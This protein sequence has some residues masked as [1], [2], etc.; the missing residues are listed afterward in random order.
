MTEL[1]IEIPEAEP[2]RDPAPVVIVEAPPEEPGAPVE[3]V[4]DHAERLT[5][6]EEMIRQMQESLSSLSVRQDI[7]EITQETEPE[8]EPV[9]EPVVIEAPEPEPDHA[10]PEP[11]RRRRPGWGNLSL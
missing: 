1:T 2:T 7:Q 8:P 3:A 10:E 9:A 11:Q 5:R 6:L 4:I